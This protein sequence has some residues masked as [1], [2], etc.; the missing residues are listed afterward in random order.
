M[1]LVAAEQPTCA[2]TVTW[3]QTPHASRNLPELD[4]QRLRFEIITDLTNRCSWDEAQQRWMP[5]RKQISYAPDQNAWR[6]VLAADYPTG[7][8]SSE[9]IPL[10]AVTATFFE[11]EA[12]PIRDDKPRL[13][14]V[15]QFKDT[16]WMRYHPKADLIKST[17]ALPSSAMLFRQAH[18]RVLDRERSSIRAVSTWS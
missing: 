3:P 9:E 5:Q 17:D 2:N 15:L 4:I 12:D 11:D 18:R 6:E 1:A 8:E 16:S 7:S 10:A 14:I 13:D